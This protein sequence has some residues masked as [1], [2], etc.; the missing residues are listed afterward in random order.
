MEEAEEAPKI[1][2]LSDLD[3]RDEAELAIRHPKTGEPT[4]WV[5]T[6]YGPGHPKTVEIA[7]RVAR[8]SLSELAAQKQARINGKK[9]KE[10]EQSIDK[11]RA[12]NVANIVARTKGF[13]PVSINGQMAVFTPATA[14]AMLLD[15]NRGWLFAQI[16]EFLK[17]DEN[18]I[19]PSA[20]A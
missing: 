13:S 5:W 16:L 11:I 4:T 15:R 12:D 17:D 1:L 2:D 18:F 6:F 19:R 10:D 7:N 8:D 14:R 9:W 3:A 20:K